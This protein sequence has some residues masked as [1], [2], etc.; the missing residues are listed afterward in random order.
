MTL[1]QHARNKMR[2]KINDHPDYEV[3]ACGNIFSAKRKTKR[4]PER[5]LKPELLPN[6]YLRVVLSE[7]GKIERLLVHRIVAMMFIERDDHNRIFVNHID[8]NKKNNN[9]NNLE[10]V[11]HTENMEHAKSIGLIRSG[12]DV[13]Q[14]KFSKAQILK[15]YDEYKKGYSVRAISRKLGVYHSLISKILK[16]ETYG[17]ILPEVFDKLEPRHKDYN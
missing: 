13:H 6:G 1:C 2:K 15:I 12:V 8:G 7:N 11:T 4:S 16:G 17:G 10:W 14:S 9:K 5:K 3:D